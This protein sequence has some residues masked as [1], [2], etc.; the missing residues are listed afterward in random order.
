MGAPAIIGGNGYRWRGRAIRTIRKGNSTCVTMPRK[1]ST[2]M[3]PVGVAGESQYK[4]TITASKNSG[5]GALLVN[6]FGGKNYDGPHISIYVT[7]AEMRDYTVAV[8]V[9]KFPNNLPMYLRV[10]R[11]N[12][13]TGNVFIQTVQYSHIG[14]MPQIPREPKLPRVGEAP[15]HKVEK[16][17]N[18]RQK[19][20]IE[21][22]V[23]VPKEDTTM[24]FKPY[25]TPAR[26]TTMVSRVLIKN[27]ED[28]PK[29]SIIT[30]TRD[31]LDL[32]KKCYEA[33]NKNTSYPNWE[34]VV[35]DSASTDGTEEYF[36]TLNDPRVKFIQRGTVE[37]SFSSINNELAAQS[38]GEYLLFLNNDTEPQP[39]WLYNLM[40]KIHRHQEIGIVGSQL[41]YSEGRIQHAGI[42]FIPQGPAN[43]GKSVLGSFP[44]GYAEQDRFLQA[45]TGACMLIRA[46]DFRIVG[47][48][49]P[50]YYFCYEDVDLC[51]K[52]RYNLNKKVLYVSDSKVLHA[53][54]VTQ[55]KHKTAGEK[56]QIGIRAFK[57]RWMSKIKVDFPQ[58][59]RDA[60][61]DLYKIDVSFVTC[62]NNLQQYRNYVV[63]SLFKNDTQK[64][65]EIIPVL[66][67][68]NP[69]SAAEALNIGLDKARGNIVV[70]CHQDVIYYET[71][72]DMMYER[73][74]EI[75]AGNH[76]WGVIGTAGIT[77]RDDTV[78][79]V[80]GIKGSLQ[81]QPNKRARVYEVQTVDE[82]CM[83]IK[84]NSGLRFDPVTF[85]GFHFYGPDLC[86]NSLSKGLK[87]FGILCPLVHDSSSGSLASGKREFMRLLNALA[88]KWR[89]KF[90]H[91]RTPT[92]VIRKRSI[93]TFV[94]FKNK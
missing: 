44:K 28:V 24:K 60:T 76:N 22:P 65:Y 58:L 16:S 68:G 81:W 11:P 91:I 2:I 29:V 39:F 20:K 57:E 42:A 45:V 79:V 27:P 10:W 34:W 75:E 1:D 93:R 30:P 56:Q 82:H 6:F 63:G 37:G 7:G 33:I 8:P 48:F 14:G 90:S 87:N 31:G 51:L 12:D 94:R 88:K 35:G 3:A 32:I 4:I 55:K 15:S 92:S 17:P 71:W 13:A 25:Q 73:I 21:P 53:E 85:N 70:F 18:I 86:L 40:A 54:S 43:L 74:A 52:V 9:P 5:N 64:T 80:H 89:P 49:D 23:I 47:G 61:K 84:R 77:K 38:T 78:G 36:K 59:Q 41:L 62:V 46:S 50:I 72:I 26:A 19:K 83:I 69:Y 66:N 67:F